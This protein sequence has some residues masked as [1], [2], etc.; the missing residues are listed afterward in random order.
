M[1]LIILEMISWRDQLNWMWKRFFFL[2]NSRG[3]DIFLDDNRQAKLYNASQLN[4]N[5]PCPSKVFLRI[6]FSNRRILQMSRDRIQG[7]EFVLLNYSNYGVTNWCKTLE[8]VIEMTQKKNRLLLWRNHGRNN[9]MF[10]WKS[11]FVILQG[12]GL[13]SRSVSPWVPLPEIILFHCIWHD[14]RLWLPW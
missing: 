1:L 5:S 12:R 4:Y 7:N 8:L 9:E 13:I 11:S 6:F 2:S 3:F 10:S 14:I